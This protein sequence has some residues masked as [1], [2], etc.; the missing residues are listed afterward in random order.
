LPDRY[1]QHTF[2]NGLTLLG[3]KMPG[4]QSAAM[5]L[6]IAAGAS[7]DPR[8]GSGTGAVLSDLVLRGAGARDSRALTD[9]LDSL[10]LQRSASVGVHH[11]RFSCAALASKVMEGLSVYADIIRRP[12]MPESGFEAARDLALQSLQGIEDEPRQKVLI[13]LREWHFPWPYGRSTMGQKAELEKLTLDLCKLHHN[14]RYQPKSAILSFAGNIE[15][16]QIKELT[17]RYFADWTP[18]DEGKTEIIPPPGRIHHEQ[19]ESEQTHI[20]IAY[21]S[22]EETDPEYYAMRLGIEVLSGGMSG[23]L[24]TEVREKRALVYNVSAGYTSLKGYGS[25]L[26]YAGT[27]NDRAQETLDTIITELHRLSEGVTKEELARAKTG[28]KAATIMQGESTS[29]RAGSIA[30]DFFIRGR[31]RTLEEVKS[32]IDAVTLDQVNAYLKKHRPQNFTI[33]TVGP[34]KLKMPE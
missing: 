6:L 18:L 8:E 13:K 33:V 3:E 7:I 29:A 14:K 25:I 20:G 26:G 15:F 1:F 24:F 17:A 32:A 19:H 4:M 30:H 2:P 21:P 5:T 16:A 31:I 10:G 12:H 27:S 22:I 11:S 9:Y 23:R 34:K 28:V